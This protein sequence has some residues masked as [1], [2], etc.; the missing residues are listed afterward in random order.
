MTADRARDAL[1]PHDLAAEAG[2]LGALLL[3]WAPLEGPL[4][5]VGV[6]DFHDPK[7]A[8]I[9]EAIGRVRAAGDAPDVVTV[10]HE[11]KRAGTAGLLAGPA[12]LVRLVSNAPSSAAAAAHAKIVLEAAGLRRLTFAMA[13][14][15][16]AVRNGRVDEAYKLA[17]DIPS[18][19]AGLGVPTD[20]ALGR[21]DVAAAM[22]GDLEQP[23]PTQLR[24]SDGVGLLY[25]GGSHAIHGE[26][27]AGKTFLALEAARQEVNAGRSVIM[28][29]YE[30]SGVVAAG[31]LLA[32]NVDADRVREHF[33]YL[34]WPHLDGLGLAQLASLGAKYSPSL[35]VVDSMAKA[36]AAQGLDEDRAPDVLGWFTTVGRVLNG[37]TLLLLD[38]VTKANDQRGRWARGSSAKLGEVD[39][40]FTMRV[41]HPW[42][43]QQPGRARLVVSKDRHGAIGPSGSTVAVIHFEPVAQ[44]EIME[45]RIDPPA[46]S[47]P[48]HGPT[49]CMAA[50]RDLLADMAPQ[51][52]SQKAVE[53]G[54]RR[55]ERGFRAETVRDALERLAAD[56]AAPVTVRTGS[57]NA[58]LY[59]HRE[60]DPAE[61]ALEE[62]AVEVDEPF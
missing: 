42:S 32:L 13:E 55:I 40:A 19:A 7:H 53:D 56:P 30:S 4:A 26:P 43:R 12:D 45:I 47:E 24:R 16:E 15:H 6:D 49:D 28:L 8:V 46:E 9:F 33:I 11:L 20:R 10:N 14:V 38:H 62:K 58:R 35:V 61:L 44:G 59:R 36:L 37:S 21:V 31:R 3:D 1:P 52:L 5:A 39:A 25:P 41:D 51:E 17:A 18:V 27:E 57:R 29:D 48:W 34:Q 23:T 60:P 54:L 22:E 2:V 50:C